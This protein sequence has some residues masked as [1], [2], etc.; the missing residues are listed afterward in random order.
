MLLALLLTFAGIGHAQIAQPPTPIQGAVIEGRIVGAKSQPLPGVMVSALKQETDP[1]GRVMPRTAGMTMTDDSGQ[2]RFAGLT[3]GR[4][5]IVAAPVR[6]L[7]LVASAVKSGA[8][9]ATP[10]FYPGVAS[11]DAAQVITLAA[12]QIFS[13]LQFSLLSIPG[14]EVRGVVVDERGRPLQQVAVTLM[15][16]QGDGGIGGPMA[17]YTDDQ[18]AF[19]ISG[20]VPGNYR[21]VAGAPMMTSAGDGSTVVSG[22]F[23]GGGVAV[24]G[25]VFVGGVAPTGGA[26]T[27][28]PGVS[29][30]GVGGPAVLPPGGTAAT[31]PTP[32]PTLISTPVDVVVGSG[33][34]TGVKIFVRLRQP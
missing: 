33:D 10:T 26:A 21:V 6:S 15:I 16:D 8:A 34:V 11:A 30:G 24:T 12:D 29:V 22:G 20:V 7:S 27:G 5:V 2:F 3:G 17:A 1:S 4:Y 18:G 23:V 19:R 32:M 14:Y 28:G 9:V 25:G 31:M 13:D